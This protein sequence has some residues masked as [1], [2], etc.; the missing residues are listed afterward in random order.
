MPRLLRDEADVLRTQWWCHA[1]LKRS[2]LGKKALERRLREAA[3]LP[4]DVAE[5]PR[6]VFRYAAGRIVP[7]D[8]PGNVVETADQLYP[9]SAALFR[10]VM[11][12]ALARK[13]PTSSAAQL[14]AESESAASRWAQ[15]HSP[16]GIGQLALDPDLDAGGVLTLALRTSGCRH[17]RET[18]TLAMAARQWFAYHWPEQFEGQL[19]QLLNSRL[20]AFGRA[21][22]LVSDRELF[23][24]PRGSSGMRQMIFLMFC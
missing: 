4:T 2:E 8:G 19:L 13:P 3:G 11:W 21:G 22:G 17:P 20:P 16:D 10:S 1:L 14:V 23:D 6:A 24:G 12:R 18:P 9:G 5:L 7:Q 15:L